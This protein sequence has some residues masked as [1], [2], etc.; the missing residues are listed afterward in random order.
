MHM[1]FFLPYSKAKTATVEFYLHDLCKTGQKPSHNLSKN[2]LYDIGRALVACFIF[3]AWHRIYLQW[4]ERDFV[5]Q[6]GGKAKHGVL[7]TP[8]S[9]IPGAHIDQYTGHLNF[10]I[11]RET[12]SVREVS[13]TH[14]LQMN[15]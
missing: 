5:A 12:T 11:I 13:A 14:S 2:S 1:K 8:L 7:L 15:H 4:R 3:N 9:Y 10:F 6:T